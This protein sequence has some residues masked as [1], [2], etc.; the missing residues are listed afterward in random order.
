MVKGTLAKH[1]IAVNLVTLL[2]L[3]EFFLGGSLEKKLS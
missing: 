2:V 3:S 1:V